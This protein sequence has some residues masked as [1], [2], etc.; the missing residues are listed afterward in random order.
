[1]CCLINRDI[2][3]YIYFS[4]IPVPVLILLGEKM[5]NVKN[6]FSTSTNI[7][8]LTKWS[9]QQGRSNEEFTY[10][11]N[12]WPDLRL[13][14]G[15]LPLIVRVYYPVR[16]NCTLCHPQVLNGN[17]QVKLPEWDDATKQ[18]SRNEGWQLDVDGWRLKLV[19]REWEGLR[20]RS[21]L[22]YGA[23]WRPVSGLPVWQMDL[24]LRPRQAKEPRQ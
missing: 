10:K 12:W 13:G 21:E 3:I 14:H 17:Y 23:Q 2:Y 11:G 15:K 22:L 5:L 18:P 8:T 9:A 20:H 24:P 19:P 4:H 6:T 7:R 1:M 16:G